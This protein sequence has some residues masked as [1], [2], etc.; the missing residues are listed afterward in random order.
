[1]KE[2]LEND[3]LKFGGLVAF[4]GGTGLLTRFYEFS[5]AQRDVSYTWTEVIGFEVAIP[6]FVA[7]LGLITLLAVVGKGWSDKHAV[8]QFAAIIPIL[9]LT[10]HQWA[11]EVYELVASGDPLTQFIVY[12][13]ISGM[14]LFAVFFDME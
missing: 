3:A 7:I 8:N 9:F 5:V 10:V 2:Y 14:G 6:Y 4:L 1:M 13:L 12:V 11:D